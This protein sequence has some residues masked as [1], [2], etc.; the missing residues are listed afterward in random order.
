MHFHHFGQKR[1]SI[2]YFLA[3]ERISTLK[4]GYRAQQ[5][6]VNA[7]VRNSRIEN[8][9]FTKPTSAHSLLGLSVVA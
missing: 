2:G 6:A 7:A 9:S 5:S 4:P 8:V 1:V 3:L